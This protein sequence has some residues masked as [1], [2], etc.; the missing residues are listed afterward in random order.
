[1]K[2]AAA[3]VETPRLEMPDGLAATGTLLN[4]PA[5]ATWKFGGSAGTHAGRDEPAI[6]MMKATRFAV[7]QP[8][9]ELTDLYATV[10]IT[11][12]IAKGDKITVAITARTI[13][14]G[15]EDG[16]AVA[17][18][19]IQGSA[20]PFESFASNRFK[21]GPNWQMIKIETVAPRDFTPGGSELQVFFGGTVQEV[22]LGPVYIFRQP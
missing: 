3:R 13:S 16:K 22:D 21:V 12:A 8:H 2:V 15:A 18:A 14:S 7:A 10:P 5:Q 9:T 19:R 11:E 1:M 4:N 6:W 20:P 17:A